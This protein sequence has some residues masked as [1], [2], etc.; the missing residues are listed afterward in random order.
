MS[1]LCNKVPEDNIHI[2]SGEWAVGGKTS[3][4]IKLQSQ[5]ITGSLALERIPFI[6]H[7]GLDLFLVLLH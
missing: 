1:Y 2:K 7:Y 4:W 3:L 6:K 5:L